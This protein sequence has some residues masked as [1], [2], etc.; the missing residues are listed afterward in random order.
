MVVLSFQDILEALMVHSDK[1]FSKRDLV[2]LFKV[3]GG[4][5]EKI[6][7]EDILVSLEEEGKIVDVTPQRFKNMRK[8]DLCNPPRWY[9]YNTGDNKNIEG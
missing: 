8:Y 6:F 1:V 3:T 4:E 5:S 9:Q 2:D 7:I